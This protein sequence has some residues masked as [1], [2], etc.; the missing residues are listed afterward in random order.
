[1]AATHMNQSE[2]AEYQHV[3]RKTV[4]IW[5]QKGL[6]SLNRV[7]LVDVAATDKRLREHFGVLPRN[8]K[9]STG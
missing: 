6:V 2:Y 4:T 3:S 9:A 7:G 1:M 8:R 5:K